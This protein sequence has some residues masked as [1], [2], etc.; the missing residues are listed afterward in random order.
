MEILVLRWQSEII[1]A[2]PASWK[3]TPKQPR[4]QETETLI[5]SPVK[6]RETL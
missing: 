4:E 3:I 2:S 5:P 6:N 1:S